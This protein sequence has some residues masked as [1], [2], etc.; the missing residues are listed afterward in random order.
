MSPGTIRPAY[1]FSPKDSDA[2]AKYLLGLP[3]N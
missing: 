3:A 2:I 1:K